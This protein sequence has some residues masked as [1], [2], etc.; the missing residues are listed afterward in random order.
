[1]LD[2]RCIAISPKSKY[3]QSPRV[4]LIEVKRKSGPAT[5]N[6]MFHPSITLALLTALMQDSL[7][8]DDRIESDRSESD[9]SV[10]DRSVSDGDCVSVDAAEIRPI[11]THSPSPQ[12]TGFEQ[13]GPSPQP[14]QRWSF[15]EQ[16][17]G[18]G[19]AGNTIAAELQKIQCAMRTELSDK[20]VDQ[21]TRS[22][23]QRVYDWRHSAE[24]RDLETAIAMIN[25]RRR[26]DGFSNLPSYSTSYSNT[27]A[28]ACVSWERWINRH[29]FS[30]YEVGLIV[31]V[32]VNAILF[33][34]LMWK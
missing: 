18:L 22:L 16:V 2:V 28:S 29:E 25:T 6:M 1:M 26:F 31:M 11:L 30:R 27:S 32:L 17:R 8:T 12:G 4:H 9:R 24:T 15:N 34:K 33:A 20:D 3:L 21:A 13:Y 10:S 14:I 23:M 5:V 19:E 7:C